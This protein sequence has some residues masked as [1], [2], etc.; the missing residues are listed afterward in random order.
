MRGP[1]LNATQ[2]MRR[3]LLAAVTPIAMAAMKQT[4]PSIYTALESHADLLNSP[5]IGCDGNFAYA[6]AQ[7]N[8][9]P[10][11]RAADMGIYGGEHGDVRDNGGYFSHM[12][13][14]SDLPPE[15]DPRWF[16]LLYASVFIMLESGTSINFSGLRFHGGT[17]PMAP[18]G[19]EP[20]DDT[21]RFVIIC[22]PPAGMTNGNTRYVFGALP[23][24]KHD[25]FYLSPEM[26]NV[27]DFT[28]EDKAWCNRATF[29]DDGHILQTPEQHIN[30]TLHSLANINTF[31]VS[32]LPPEYGIQMNP[33]LFL[34]SFSFLVEQKRQ[35]PVLWSNAL[36]WRSHTPNNNEDLLHVEQNFESKQRTRRSEAYKSWEQYRRAVEGHIPYLVAKAKAPPLHVSLGKAAGKVLE[37]EKRTNRDGRPINSKANMWEAGGGV[38]GVKRKTRKIDNTVKDVNATMQATGSKQHGRGVKTKAKVTVQVLSGGT[39]K[40]IGKKS[41]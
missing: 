4:V 37:K 19:V 11:Q 2:V 41:M 32:Q 15:Y 24:P 8:I 30:W 5:R 12:Y 26:M 7:L 40:E 13:V 3:N 29:I 14:A 28:N 22:Y 36:G 16:F 33:D 20:R 21:Y 35:R 31:F 25:T 34:Q 6:T 39:P 1:A 23:G 18:P 17:A 38:L 10:A 9:A 27:D